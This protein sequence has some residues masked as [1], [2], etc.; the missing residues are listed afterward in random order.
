M[1]LPTPSGTFLSIITSIDS[2]ALDFTSRAFQQ[3]VKSN[4]LAIT[5]VGG[6]YVIIYGWRILLGVS[7]A[8]GRDAILHIVK[9]TFIYSMLVSWPFVHEYVI[10]FFVDM[11]FALAGTMLGSESTGST[12]ALFAQMDQVLAKGTS[13]ALRMMSECYY[14]C[15]AWII[16]LVIY[17]IVL[18]IALWALI[19]IAIAK[20]G[21]AV[22]LGMLPI[23]L[24][25]YLFSGTKGIFEGYLRQIITLALYPVMTAGLM[26]IAMKLITL[27]LDGLLN[28]VNR[29]PS[30]V[31]LSSIVGFIL[32]GGVLIFLFRHMGKFCSGIGNGFSLEKVSTAYNDETKR[33]RQWRKSSGKGSVSK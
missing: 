5:A 10:W 22:L 2:V 27:P 20:I 29:Q 14:L 7:Q 30:D 9:F 1:E 21:L 26:S 17:V 4:M 24:V 12:Q 6:L 28:I 33:F 11:P 19:Y 13:T 18:L 3:L 23:F 8:S 32:I 31:S 25:L 16:A 15:S